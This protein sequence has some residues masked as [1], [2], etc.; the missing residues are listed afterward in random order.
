[1]EDKRRKDEEKLWLDDVEFKALVEGKGRLYSRKI[2]GRL[3]EGGGSKTG[4]DKPGGEQDEC[5]TF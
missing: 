5:G 4:Q 2:Q 1:M 3:V